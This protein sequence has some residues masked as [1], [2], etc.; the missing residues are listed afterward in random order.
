M[1]RDLCLTRFKLLT[2]LDRLNVYEEILGG[3]IKAGEL[4]DHEK[5]MQ[6]RSKPILEVALDYARVN[7]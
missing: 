3:P 6:I 2:Y 7:Y 5:Y 4:F 1:Q